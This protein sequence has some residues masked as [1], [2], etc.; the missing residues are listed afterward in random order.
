VVPN[1]LIVTAYFFLI[2]I[3]DSF[4][5]VF[6][7]VTNSSVIGSKSILPPKSHST[8]SVIIEAV[9][10]HLIALLGYLQVTVFPDT[11]K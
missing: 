11:V 3:P 7:L 8:V 6:T 1:P 10:V 4:F 9:T 2:A 5:I